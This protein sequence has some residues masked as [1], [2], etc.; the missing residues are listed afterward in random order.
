MSRLAALSLLSLALALG[1]CSAD[2][3]TGIAGG[4]LV[5]TWSLQSI[6]NITLPYLLA[7]SGANKLELMSDVID[8]ADGGSFT[9]ATI[10]RSTLSGAVTMD[11]IPNTGSYA[12]AGSTATFTFDSDSS[13]AHGTLSGNRLTLN[14]SGVNLLYTR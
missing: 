1:A 4:S 6:N 10:V 11:T 13:V 9:D 5:G 14:D 7:Q 12:L 2:R 3:T 8:A